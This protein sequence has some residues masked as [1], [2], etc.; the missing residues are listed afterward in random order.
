MSTVINFKEPFK[1]KNS[2]DTVSHVDLSKVKDG[3]FFL[4][5]KAYL[6]DDTGLKDVRFT[7]EIL[8][9]EKL[10]TLE[11]INQI[12]ELKETIRFTIDKDNIEFILKEIIEEDETI[13][14]NRN[15]YSKI[16]DAKNTL[17]EKAES[18]K[19]FLLFENEDIECKYGRID[20]NIVFNRMH[21]DDKNKLIIGEAVK[22]DNAFEPKEIHLYLNNNNRIDIDLR[23]SS[24]MIKTSSSTTRIKYI[25]IEG[26]IKWKYS[27]E[28]DLSS[29]NKRF[30]MPTE[31][32]LPSLDK[33]NRPATVAGL[34]NL[35]YRNI[36]STLDEIVKK[37]KSLLAIRLNIA[38]YMLL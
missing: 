11:C 23:D 32:R 31:T 10:D 9:N 2:K 20:D 33:D 28:N 8:Y 13:F 25:K 26:K 19:M 12:E 35:L 3:I 24:D 36:A 4:S 7:S 5:K 34:S 37:N 38:S 6:I 29:T 18:A 14:N 16:I 30:F 17:K 22:K 21:I 27:T 1:I 15:I